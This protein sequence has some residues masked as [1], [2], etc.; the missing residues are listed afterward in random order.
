MHLDGTAVDGENL[1][2][3]LYWSRNARIRMSW[4]L[5][6]LLSRLTPAAFARYGSVQSEKVTILRATVPLTCVVP[7]SPAQVQ[8][9]S[10]NQRPTA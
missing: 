10:A 2:C 9:L 3:N 8:R 1:I 6:S 5:K 4:R 7:A